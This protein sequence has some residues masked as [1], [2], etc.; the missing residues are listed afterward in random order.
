MVSL[1]SK[2]GDDLHNNVKKYLSAPPPKDFLDNFGRFSG[3]LAVNYA[4]NRS[5]AS[6]R[7]GIFMQRRYKMLRGGATCFDFMSQVPV[8]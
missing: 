7:G 3:V 1:F 2:N 6:C 5:Q 8:V 4:F